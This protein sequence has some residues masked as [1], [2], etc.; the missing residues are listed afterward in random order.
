MTQKNSHWNSKFILPTKD[1]NLDNIIEKSSNNNSLSKNH[2]IISDPKEGEANEEEK[3]IE[4]KILKILDN[5]K[6]KENWIS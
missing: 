6:E 3:L 1:Q 4:A 5:E 2:Q